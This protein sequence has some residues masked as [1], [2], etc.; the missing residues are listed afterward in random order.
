MLDPGERESKEFAT[1]PPVHEILT[2]ILVWPK[3][4]PSTYVYVSQCRAG[5]PVTREENL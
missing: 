5:F 4:S 1:L 3:G 2:K